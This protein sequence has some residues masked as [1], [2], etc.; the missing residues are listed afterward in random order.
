VK[1]NETI[2]DVGAFVYACMHVCLL[3]SE[4]KCLMSGN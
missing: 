3:V 1:L 2:E 4:G